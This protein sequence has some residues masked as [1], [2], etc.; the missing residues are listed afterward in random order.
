MSS[1][2]KSS[3]SLIWN[4]KGHLRDQRDQSMVPETLCLQWFRS[5]TTTIWGISFW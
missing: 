1:F 2:E 3:Q 4:S 5:Y